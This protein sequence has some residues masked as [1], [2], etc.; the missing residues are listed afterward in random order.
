MNNTK[1]DRVE[2][3]LP[4]GYALEDPNC[5][6]SINGASFLLPRGKRVLV[7][8]FVAAELRR[9]ELAQRNWDARSAQLAEQ[10][11]PEL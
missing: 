1:D 4:K 11:G 10:G 5:F 6:V 3:C 8:D 7:P 2:V 9:A